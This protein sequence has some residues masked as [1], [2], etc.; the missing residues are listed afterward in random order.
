[1]ILK[2]DSV[3]T[4]FS[5]TLT[6]HSLPEEVTIESVSTRIF[7]DRYDPM[8]TLLSFMRIIVHFCCPYFLYK[9]EG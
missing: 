3:Y 7:N 6:S 8:K 9:L 1:M 4:V 2:G 5:M